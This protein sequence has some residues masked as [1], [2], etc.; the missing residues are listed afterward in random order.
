MENNDLE[1]VF[2]QILLVL[3]RDLPGYDRSRAKFRT[4]L[5]AVIRHAA[6]AHLRKVRGRQKGEALLALEKEGVSN[7]EERGA[8]TVDAKLSD[9]E[10]LIEDEWATYISNLAMERVRA[11]FSGQALEVFSLGLDGLAAAEIAD[12]TGLAVSSVYTLRKRVK[13]RLYQEI[14]ALTSELEQ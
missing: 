14:R 13:K 4:W 9:L 5:G 6:Y 8:G 11:V 12:R 1:D 10:V 2:Q 7:L 3:T